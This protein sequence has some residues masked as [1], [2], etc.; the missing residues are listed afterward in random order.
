[1]VQWLRICC[2][3]RTWVRSLVQEYPTCHGTT[4]PILLSQCFRVCQP[5]L[6]KPAG[7]QPML[8]NKRSHCNEAPLHSALQQRVPSHTHLP[9]LEKAHVQQG[10]AS[11]A[12]INKSYLKKK[13]R[14]NVG[15]PWWSSPG[16]SMLPLQVTWV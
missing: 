13:R 16:K 7:L 9:Q 2:Q 15:L 10:R 5:Q 6:L 14:R 8:C 11:R 3:F 4:D 1:M 12:K